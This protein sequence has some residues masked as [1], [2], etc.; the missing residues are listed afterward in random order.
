[1]KRDPIVITGVGVLSPNGTD[2]ESY[3]AATAQGLS[4][5]RTITRFDPG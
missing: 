1:M 4:G 3:F 2:R 5:V